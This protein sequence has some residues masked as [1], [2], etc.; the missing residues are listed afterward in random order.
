MRYFQIPEPVDMPGFKDVS[1]NPAKM[2]F[3]AFLT[4]NVWIDESWR[5]DKAKLDLFFVLVEKLEK[6]N[7]PKDWVALTDEEWEVF[8][9]LA[10]MQGVKLN[11]NVVIPFNRLMQAVMNAATKKPK[12]YTEPPEQKTSADPE[13]PTDQTI[14]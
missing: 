7:K 14:N 3:H 1:G 8:H 12:E 5:K 10:T 4:Q 9:P 13:P 6:S 11:P 2:D